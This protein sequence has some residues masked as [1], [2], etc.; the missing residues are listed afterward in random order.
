[1]CEGHELGA[2]GQKCSGKSIR[3]GV[4]LEEN[5]SIFTGQMRRQA[6]GRILEAEIT[7]VEVRM[8]DEEHLNDLGSL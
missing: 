8:H 4:K 1:M 6:I 3:Q 2:E 7:T 5:E